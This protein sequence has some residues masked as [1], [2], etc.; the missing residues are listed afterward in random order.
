MMVRRMT[1][2]TTTTGVMTVAGMGRQTKELEDQW[3]RQG[4]YGNGIL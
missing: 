1:T 4:L 2:M 3:A